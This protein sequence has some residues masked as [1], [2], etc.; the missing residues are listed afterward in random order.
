M[1][2]A[3]HSRSPWGIASGAEHSG[4]HPEFLPLLRDAGVT[5]LRYFAEWGSIQPQPGVWNW[6]WSD[7]FVAAAKAN[8]IRVAG[9]FLYFAPW[10][11]SDGGT[12][13]FPVK[14]L[15][16]WREYVKA[17]VARYKDDIEHWEVW[18]EGN[19]P[20]FNRH[21]TPR[22]YADLVREAYHAAKEANPVCKIGITCAAF[23]L[24]YFHQAIQAGAAG[25]FD[26]VCVHPYNS[27]GYVFGSEP[28]YLAMA[29]N[30]RAMLAANRQDAEMPLWISEIG[31]TTTR[32]PAQ[33]R[34]QAQALAKSFVL[35]IVQGFERT[36][37]FEACGPK[38]GDGVHAILDDDLAPF[39][40]YHALAAMTQALGAAPQYVGWTALDGRCYGFVF[41]DGAHAVMAAWAAAPG[42]TVSFAV[43]VS[44][45]DLRG[46]VSTLPRGQSLALDDE[47]VFVRGLPA[48]LVAAARA[49]AARRFPWAP[50]F[51]DAG[52]V[53]CQLGPTNEEHGLRQGDNDP[54]SDGLS[55]PGTGDGRSYRS[56]DLRKGRPFLY[57]NVDS[58]YMGW[59]DRDVEIT[60]VARRAAPNHPTV[61]TLVY[62]SETGY[63]ELGKRTTTTGLNPEMLFES[64]PYRAPELWYLAPGSEWQTHT[65][66]FP[67]ACFIQKWGWTF[68]VNVEMSAGDVQVSEVRVRRALGR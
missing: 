41:Q 61:M 42:A 44:I 65:W 57:F 29:G 2:F 38:Y 32:D 14:D 5:W 12:R 47:P 36:C 68:E 27:I 33:L 51:R 23:D 56:T 7:R 17:T 55:V 40:A 37:W 58:T 24:H 1:T 62:E 49:N 19:S 60:V 15:Q 30:V 54:R 53:W 28:S 64:E 48:E 3:D 67:D 16:A 35:G 26:Y 4:K 10:A 52:D 45:T 25:C 6:E 8:G 50:D 34:R 66:R 39:P 13:G 21:G 59:G 63:H 11:S 20:A 43:P 31:L 46:R 22:D 9:I 18:N